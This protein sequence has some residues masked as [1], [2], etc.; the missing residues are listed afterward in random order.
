MTVD[1]IVRNGKLVIPGVGI[2]EADIGIEGEKI[3]QIGRKLSP[4]GKIIDA[5]GRY[6]FP[7][8]VDTH[9]HYGHFNE[10][11]DEM[12]SESRCLA[13]S[14]ITT[15]VVLL[16]RCI[17]NMEGW[18]ERREDPELFVK[19]L[20]ANPW[21]VMW[22]A[23][24]QKIFPDVI[25]KSESVSTNDFAFHL[26]IV[27][28]HQLEEMPY[29]QKEYGIASFKCWPGMQA[30]VAL[31]PSDLW[32]FLEK[33]KE[34]SVTPLINTI[35]SDMQERKT[36]EAQERAKSDKTLVGPCLVKES[37]G[38][39]IVETLELHQ[40]LRIARELAIPTLLIVHVATGESVKL[41]RRYRRE[42][43]LNVEGEAGGVW[44]SL[45]WPEVGEKLGYR[46]TCIF[47]Q[48][49]DRKDV[50][51]LW[52]GIRTGEITCAGTDGVISPRE[53]YPDGK[54]NPLY[55]PPPTRE[56]P[57]MGFP[58]HICHFPVVLHHGMERGIPLARI[59]EVCASNPAKLMGLYPKKGTIAIGSDAD[60][61][62]MDI[63]NRHV[64]KIEELYT[65][66]L[67][68]PWEGVELNCWPAL[69]MLR[70]Q[71]IFEN[72]KQVKEKA[73]RYQPR[74]PR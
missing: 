42:T 38:A 51:M 57:G 48:I 67:Y 39:S 5:K 29:Y 3:A 7:G 8:C 63:G 43:G 9:T 30:P 14:G 18:K 56:R 4:T 32:L 27:N 52:D 69:T 70:G 54:P 13:F 45:S 60:L 25:H 2:V 66:A 6:I 50:D 36:Q 12:E 55:Q 74:Y 23:S 37:L 33:C 17:K 28:T 10:F 20:H 35:S 26:A 24:Y 40:T 16:D 53:K 73:G 65:T 34:L 58:S 72:G 31:G 46:A 1:C 49:S 59:A 44:L 11:Y 47:P 19:P 71:V 22:K 21:N 62:I 68:N 64:V 15:S 61:V 41:L